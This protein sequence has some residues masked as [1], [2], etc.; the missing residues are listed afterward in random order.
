MTN[1]RM[2]KKHTDPASTLSNRV[3]PGLKRLID[4]PDR[5]AGRPNLGL[6][7]NQASIGPDYV[8]AV[9]L[10]DR[11]FPGRLKVLMGPQHGFAGEKQDNMVESDHSRDDVTGRPIYSLYGEKRHPDPE[12]LNGLDLLLIDLVDVGARVYTFAQTMSYCLEAAARA[13]VRVMVLDRPNPI[14][15]EQIEGNLLKPD[16]AS[17]VGLWPIPMRHGLTLGELARYIAARLDPKPDLEV[18]PVLHWHRNQ[19]FHQTGLPWVM[20]SPNMPM[21]ETTLLYPGQVIWEGTNISEGRG[22]TRPFHLIGAPFIDPHRLKTELDRYDLP[23]ARFRPAS[24]QPTF[25]KFQGQ[26]CNGLEIHPIDPDRYHPY[27]TSLTI[28]EVLM[29]LYP[30]RVSWK[31]PPYEYEYERNP[32]DLITGDRE[33]RLGLEAGRTARNLARTWVDD[34]EAFRRQRQKYLLY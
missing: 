3:I 33:I 31:K 6:L 34:L 20:P 17:F 27:L 24:F 26:V 29:K 11:A 7:A 21:P 28:L 2:K 25:H 10:I 13:G 22:T 18:L 9:E 15:G 14:G 12:M 8:H 19:Y 1:A 23:G 5:I 30:D 32:L 16:C 4:E